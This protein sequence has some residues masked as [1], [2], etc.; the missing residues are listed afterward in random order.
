M[1]FDIKLWFKIHMNMKMYLLKSCGFYSWKCMHVHLSLVLRNVCSFLFRMLVLLFPYNPF[2][3]Y[4]YT[5]LEWNSISGR[6][7]TYVGRYR[8]TDI[9]SLEAATEAAGRIRLIMEAKLSPGPPIS[10]L[11]LH[12]DNSRWHELGINV[13]SGNF[14][15]AKVK[16]SWSYELL[17][18]LFV[19]NSVPWNKYQLICLVI[20]NFQSADRLF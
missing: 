5:I 13:A 15:A 18:H 10:N 8:I 20:C 16:F 3:K 17:A 12:G 14:L 11:R 4:M 7:A 6:K 9:D 19:L 1:L 2:L